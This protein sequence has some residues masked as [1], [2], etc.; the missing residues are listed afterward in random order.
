MRA[1]SHA[2]QSLA[3]SR[4][5]ILPVM[6]A[7]RGSVG[8]VPAEIE[9]RTQARG[10]KISFRR[11][12]PRHAAPASRVSS[13]LT[14]TGNRGQGPLA[15]MRTAL[16]GPAAKTVRNWPLVPANSARAASCSPWTLGTR[17]T[18]DAAA[19]EEGTGRR[20]LVPMGRMPDDVPSLRMPQIRTLARPAGC[21]RL[22]GFWPAR[23]CICGSEQLTKSDRSNLACMRMT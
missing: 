17:G 9:S 8:P 10:R 14:S 23:V 4:V 1:A 2:R 13:C 3:E 11:R 20:R 15:V 5:R 12:S 21:R 16:T 18:G 6:A 22:Q 7:V 19:E